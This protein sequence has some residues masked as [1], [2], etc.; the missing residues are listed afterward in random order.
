M[1]CLS[2]RNLKYMRTFAE[3]WQDKAIVQRLVAQITGRYDSV[4]LLVGQSIVQQPA[5]RLPADPHAGKIPSKY[6]P[7]SNRRVA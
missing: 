5:A 3:A 2:P 7:V 1:K 6:G 4:T